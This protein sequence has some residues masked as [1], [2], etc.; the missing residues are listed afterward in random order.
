MRELERLG[1]YTLRQS[2]GVF[3]LGA[4]SVDL[5]R[6]A[7]LRRNWRVCDLGC[8]SGALG[9]LLLERE[10]TLELTGVDRDPK[11]AALAEQNL[12]DNGIEGRVVAGDLEDTALL[13]A[14]A[15][16]LVVSNPP[17]FAQGTGRSGGPARCEEEI[18]LAG[19]CAAAGRLTR[20]GGRFALVHRPE[21]LA[22]LLAA[23]AQAGLEPKRLRL[24][25]HR[26]DTPPC[27]VLVE[28]IRQGRPGLEVLPTWIRERGDGNE[29]GD[30]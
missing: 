4:D 11:A 15:F 6:F 10:E 12:R 7:T 1:R 28:S 13:P 21:R 30:D 5:A 17:W 2:D 25:Q 16:D 19:L 18:T 29:T 23:L 14:G 3:P 24:I 20:N 9:L 26:E 22:E 27:A 8:G